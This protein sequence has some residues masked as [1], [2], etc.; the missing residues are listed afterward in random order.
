[1]IHV[2]LAHHVQKLP[3]IGRQ[4]FDIAALTLGIDRIEGEAGLAAARQPGDDHQPV[5]RNIHV[6][7]FQIVLARA[8]NLDELLFHEASP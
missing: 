1:M 6:H 8:A 4:A 5:A 2:W 7:A 3:G